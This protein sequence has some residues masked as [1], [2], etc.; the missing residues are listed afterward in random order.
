MDTTAN[1]GKIIF[2]D[3]APIIKNDLRFPIPAN[4]EGN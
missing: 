2:E 1:I 3:K 4:G